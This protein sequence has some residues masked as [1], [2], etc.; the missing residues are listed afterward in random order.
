MAEHEEQNRQELRDFRRIV[1]QYDRKVYRHAFSMLGNREDAEEATQDVFLRVHKALYR[2]RGESSLSTWIYRITVNV[3]APR[4]LRNS[5]KM[6]SI[7]DPDQPPSHNLLDTNQ[8]PEGIYAMKETRERIAAMV[9]RLP[10]REAAAVTLFYLDQKGYREIAEILQ[11]PE[12]SVARILFE[13]R[14]RLRRMI[15]STRPR[16]EA[17]TAEMPERTR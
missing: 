14:D 7:D 15:H 16:N 10:R 5:R 9:S 6:P 17:E 1:D 8:D 12:G 4:V 13:A 11:L 3:C 2:F